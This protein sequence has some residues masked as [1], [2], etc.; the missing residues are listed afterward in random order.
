MSFTIGNQSMNILE[1]YYLM[2]KLD[3]SP[4][5]VRKKLIDN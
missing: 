2:S 3:N 1:D 5:N 4:L